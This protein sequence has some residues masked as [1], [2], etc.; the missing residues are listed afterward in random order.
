[1]SVHHNNKPLHSGLI[2][3]KFLAKHNTNIIA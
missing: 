1:L 3:T 2:L